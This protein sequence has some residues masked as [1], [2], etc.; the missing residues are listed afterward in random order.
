MTGLTINRGGG[1]P[2]GSM[3]ADR[4][5]YLTADKSRI[6]EQG[7]TD[8]AYLFSTPGFEISAAEVERLGLAL[9]DGR[10]VQATTESEPEAEEQ[11]DAPVAEVEAEAEVENSSQVG[12]PDWPLKTD[13]A[14]YLGR[15]PDGPKADLAR[16]VLRAREEGGAG[17]P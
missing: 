11:H 3:I 8:S 9:I 1:Q 16:Q 12:E 13:P 5:L 15:N 6:V 10:I 14:D 2:A 7:D 17:D 4:H